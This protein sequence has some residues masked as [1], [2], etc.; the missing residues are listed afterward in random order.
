VVPAA[1]SRRFFRPVLE[2]LEDRIAPATVSWKAPVDGFWDVGSNWDSGTVP[3]PGDDAVI[4]QAGAA[5]TVTVRNAQSV[6]SLRSKDGLALTGGSLT[7]AAAS[8]IDG[9]LALGGGTLVAN[10]AVT[11]AGTTSWTSGVIQGSSVVTNAGTITLSGTATKYVGTE[12]DNAGTMTHTGTGSLEVDGTLNNLA[13]ALYDFQTDA[14]LA[15]STGHFRNAGTVRKSAGTGTTTADSFFDN[16][17]GTLDIRS[18]TFTTND[19]YATVADTFTGGTFLVAAGA[20][21]NLTGS[22]T[23]TGTFTGSGAGTVAWTGTFLT[24]GAG[25]ATF[26][27][28]AGLFQWTSGNTIDGGP[29]GLTNLGTITLTGASNKFLS[30]VLNNAGT[31]LNSGTVDLSNRSQGTLINLPGALVDLAGDVGVSTATFINRGTLRKSG[32]IGTS[33]MTAITSSND[34]GTIDVRSGTLLTASQSSTDNGENTGGTFT[35]AGGAVLDLGNHQNPNYTTFKGNYTGSGSGTVR[36]SDGPLTVDGTGGATFDFPAGMFQWAGGWINGGTAG[37]TNVGFITL[38]GANTK[39]LGGVLNNAGT[40]THSGTGDFQLDISTGGFPGG[41]GVGILN[42]LAGGLYDMQGDRNLAQGFADAAQFNNAGT[43]RKSSGS[44]TTTV[45]APFNNLGGTIDVRSGTFRVSAGS[46]TGGTFTVATGATLQMVGSQTITGTYAGSGNGIVQWGE[47]QL[48]TLSVGAAGAT[49]DFPGGLFQWTLGKIDGG[50]AGLTNRGTMTLLGS[51]FKILSGTLHNHGTIVETGNVT[52]LNINRDG[53]IINEVDGLYDFQDD[54]LGFQASDGTPVGAFTNLGTVRKSSGAGETLIHSSVFSNEGTLEVLSGTL[55]VN[56]TTLPQLAGST[57]TGGTWIVRA[58]ATLNLARAPNLTASSASITLD[59]PGSTFTTINTLASNAGSFSLLDGRNFTTVGPFSNTGSLTVGAGSTFHVTGAYTQSAAATLHVQVGGTPASAQ[60]GRL[61]STGSAALAGTLD[62][63]LANGFGPTMGQSFPVVGFPSQSG[64]FDTITGMQS[65]RF[66]LFTAQLAATGE[67]L[68]AA[69]TTADLAFDHFDAATFPTAATLGQNVSITYTVRN[70]S[71]TPAQGDWYDSVYLSRD[72]TLDPGD[73]LLG[74]VHH[75]GDVADLSSYTETLTAPLPALADGGYHV[76][77]LADSRGLVPDPNRANNTGVSTQTMAATV[78][79]LTL[80]TPLTGT[81]ANGQDFY[82]RVVASPG[83]D[84]TVEADFSTS[85]EA[86]FYLRY[87]SLPDRTNYD[88]TAPVSALQPRLLQ[89]NPQGGAF[90]IL[91]HGREGAG[92]GTPFTLK[93]AAAGF[94]IVTFDPAQASNTGTATVSLTGS[95]FTPQTVLSLHGPGGAALDASAVQFVDA[96][97]LTATFDLTKLPIGGY[98]LQAGD[99]GRTAIALDTFTVTHAALGLLS[100]SVTAPAYV[101]VGGSITLSINVINSGATDAPAPLI[102]AQATNVAAGS[103]NQLVSGNNGHVVPPDYKGVIT[104]GYDPEPH[105]AGTQSGFAVGLINPSL[106]LIPWDTVKDSVRPSTIPADAWDAVWPSF[107]AQL[108][109]TEANFQDLVDQD[110]AT[111][112]PYGGDMSDVTDVFQFELL[113]ANGQ[114]SVPVP[115]EAI[116]AAFPAPGLPLV[117]GRSFGNTI[118]SRYRLGRL[119]RGWIDNFDISAAE[120][121]TGQV[122][123]RAGGSIRFFF[124][125][126]DGTYIA[127]PGDQGTLTRVNNAFQIR[128]A[129][130]EVTAFRSDGQLDY[131]QDPNGNRITAGYTGSQLTTL[132]HSNGSALTLAYNAQGRISQVTGPSGDIATYQYDASGEQLLSVTTKAGTTAYSYTPDATGPSAHALAS[133]TYLDG[134]HLFLQYNSRGW[135]AQ[136]EG[137]GG[138]GRLNF[139]YGINSVTATNADNHATTSGYDNFLRVRQVQDPLGRITKMDYD[140]TGNLVSVSAPGAGSAGIAYDALQDP[141]STL[142]PLGASQGFT[143]EPAHNQLAT[144]TDGLGQTTGFAYDPN[145]NPTSSTYADGS[146]EQY[147]YDAQGNL[148]RSVNRLGQTI[149]YTYNSRG[150]TTRKD[151]P[152]GAHV[153]YTYNARG[154]LATATDASGTTSLE[155]LDPQDPDLVTKITYPNGQFLQYTYQNGRRTQMVD[156]SGF[157]VNYS[158]DAAGRLESL[159]DGANNLIVQYQ[160]DPAGRLDRETNGNG[161]ATAYSYYDDGQVRTISN[162][163]PDAS[164]QSQLTYTYDQL[165]RRTSVATADGTVT[166]YGYDGA[167]RLTTVSMP[168]RVI[169]YAYDAAGNRTTVSDNGASTAY[170]VNSLNEYTAVGADGQT[171]DAA[172]N[173]VSSANGFSQTNYQYD[174]EGRLISQV[175]P[176]GTWTY[177]YDVFGNRIASS[178]NGVRTQYLVDP[179]GVGNVV[180]EYD[181]SGNLQAHYVHGLGLTSRVDAGNQSAYYQFDAVGNTTELTG[182]AGAVLNSYAY[183]PFGEALRATETIANPFKYV[184][185]A[186]VMSDGSGLDYM[187]NRWYAPDQGRFTQPDPIGLAGGTNLYA[188]VGNGPASLVD[189]S[190]LEEPLDSA[191]MEQ[192]YQ[193]FFRAMYNGGGSE[194]T[195]E[196]ADAIDSTLEGPRWEAMAQAADAARAPGTGTVAVSNVDFAQPVASVAEVEAE[197]AA[198]LAAESGAV[199]GP[200]AGLLRGAGIA[201]A[202]V[203]IATTAYAIF[204]LGIVI[205]QAGIYG[206]TGELAHCVPHQPHSFQACEDPGSDEPLNDILIG[207]LDPEFQKYYTAY[208]TYKFVTQL[209]PQ[210]HDPNDIVGPGGFGPGGFLVPAPLP[211]TIDFQ[212][213]PTAGGPAQQVV[214]TQQL[215]PGLDL[216]TFQLGDFGF[217]GLD[218][219][220]PAGRQLYHT[221]VDTRSS[222]GLFV[223]VTAAL[224]RPT[225]TVTWTLTSLDPATLDLPDDPFVGFLPPDKNASEG[226]GFVNYTVS[227]LATDPTGTVIAAQASVVFDANAPVLTPQFINTIDAGPPTSSIT[228]LPAFSPVT[229]TVHWAGQDD[230]GGSGIATYDVY[231]SDD[232][233]PFT[234]W[235]AATTATAAAYTGVDGHTYAFY[236]VATDNVGHVEATPSGAQSVTTVDATPPTSSV[237]ALPAVTGSPSFTVSWSGQDNAGGSGLASYNIYVSDNGGNFTRWQ[238]ATAQTSATWTGAVGHTYGFYSVATDNVGNREATPSAAQATTEIEVATTTQIS[239]SSPNNT[240]SQSQAVTFTA[241]VT[242]NADGAGTPAGQVHFFDQ[243]TCT[244][245]GIVSL[246]NGQASVNTSALAVGQHTILV[247]FLANGGYLSSYAALV[248][249]ILGGGPTDITN[250]TTFT[251]TGGNLV[252]S[253]TGNYWA[254][255]AT[256]TNNSNTTYQG[257]VSIVFNGLAAGTVVKGA[258]IN[259]VWVPAQMT[260]DGRYYIDVIDAASTFAPGQVVNIALQLNQYPGGSYAVQVLAGPGTR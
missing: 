39:Y 212:N 54:P 109:Q 111:L 160:Y 166:T 175:T 3:A 151:L 234:L 26:N 71:A 207:S 100:L 12:L 149:T 252:R 158:Y 224:D 140:V 171:F 84:V 65:G 108:G 33:S 173:L 147:G 240:S 211:Y 53:L 97:H 162:Y 186:G 259:G 51:A 201:G 172:G 197:V 106:T 120:D 219:S 96:N 80:G 126:A 91:L 255:A 28:P 206:V 215:D 67:V 22:P 43:V 239:S 194:H 7:V 156:P 44:G 163:A 45:R 14:G 145:G 130:G 31:I 61:I 9:S 52:P 76:I 195:R 258:T 177:E 8:R 203:Q 98:S 82:Y 235:Q 21:L 1:F 196:I 227:P 213:A 17:G 63:A 56:P 150:Q 83:K 2:A 168:G 58:G 75:V 59:G 182:A 238:A 200:A 142:D 62:V 137:D 205:G 35:V 188:Y 223:D 30:H 184:G 165:G 60:F 72:N 220:V 221:R 90:Y 87:G 218:V 170:A 148:T 41:L 193:E 217:G 20:T 231:V 241:T 105:A 141:T 24:A 4:D 88:Q 136:E 131:L 183:L 94:E 107:V 92:G 225:R 18:G 115:A 50:A 222:N 174:A 73:A 74:R 161:T 55:T 164:V 79:T 139:T 153:D 118:A 198:R 167:G 38:A 176:Q 15:A 86:E 208:K 247:T 27:F 216:D 19:Y 189:P 185:Q 25:G 95:Q 40:I 77:V 121:S 209:S 49:F 237:R 78:P 242:A 260:S 89:A 243:T 10:G 34:G 199:A 36:L 229:F 236:S 155:Y 5:F 257:P 246:V 119:G 143:Y 245:L 134:T 179:T 249:T 48:D 104:L 93:A 122:T 135:L 228:S 202:A 244:D 132:T 116:D 146:S 248:Q 204:S 178:L 102:V 99:A 181:G 13:G 57:L 230:A 159:R 251:H 37:L 190:G 103:E 192:Y 101:R 169:V 256:L 127:M 66:P 70:L 226:E 133:I 42:N 154:N 64:A 125:Q 110:T 152:G 214:V 232:G 117:F 46:H 112:A 85:P 233:G 123:V 81:I 144:F 180:A 6:H 124:R 69:S 138:A 157:A 114:M 113:K 29:N 68:T 253:R 129:T 250:Q 210:G 11:T 187:R 23:F 191:A 254:Q 16:L 128:E 47:Q 32:G